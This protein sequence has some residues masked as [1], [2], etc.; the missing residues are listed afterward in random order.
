VQKIPPRERADGGQ[1][2]KLELAPRGIASCQTSRLRRRLLFSRRRFSLHGC[3]QK[4]LHRCRH[5]HRRPSYHRACLHS[6]RGHRRPLDRHRLLDDRIHPQVRRHPSAAARSSRWA[7]RCSSLVSRINAPS[8][9]PARAAR[10]RAR[11]GCSIRCSNRSRPHRPPAGH[12]SSAAPVQ[13]PA[14][15]T[16]P[17]GIDWGIRRCCAMVFASDTIGPAW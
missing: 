4:L 3:L 14:I 10:R 15:P 11:R 2:P 5:S 16:R 9:G 7:T 6:L 12:F 17:S 1:S 8:G 13:M